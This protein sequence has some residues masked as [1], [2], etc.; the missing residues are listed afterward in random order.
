MHALSYRVTDTVSSTQLVCFTFENQENEVYHRSVNL[1][2]IRAQIKYI[3]RRCIYDF[4][5][6]MICNSRY[7]GSVIVLMSI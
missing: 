3:I 2:N 7:S 6:L 4:L 1:Y 5:T